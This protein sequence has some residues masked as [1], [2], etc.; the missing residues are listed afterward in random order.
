MSKPAW[1]P[2]SDWLNVTKDDSFTSMSKTLVGEP[3]TVMGRETVCEPK[4]VLPSL[5]HEGRKAVYEPDNSPILPPPANQISSKR[6][7]DL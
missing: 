6:N 1:Y 2:I 5:L 4:E 7:G 3:V